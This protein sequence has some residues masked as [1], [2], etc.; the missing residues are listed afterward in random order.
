L[1]FV[2]FINNDWFHHHICHPSDSLLSRSRYVHTVLVIVWG[3]CQPQYKHAVHHR[4]SWRFG[5]RIIIMII[6]MIL[7]LSSLLLLSA[8]S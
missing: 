6:I 1:R 7:L 3:V 2:R 4:H 5:S 8:L